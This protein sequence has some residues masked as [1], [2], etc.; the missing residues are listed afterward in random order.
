MKLSTI[1]FSIVL[2]TLILA[3]SL[4]VSLTYTYYKLDP[5]GF[6]ERL[7]VNIDKPELQC[8]GKCHLN[9]ISKSQNNE[10]K[11]PETLIDFK[12]ILLYASSYTRFEFLN[13]SIIKKE[14]LEHPQ[15]LYSFSSTYDYFHPPKA[16]FLHIN[17]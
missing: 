7:C 1:L 8:N 6:I 11:T 2:T 14:L 16:K 10:Q 17:I 15:N 5:L 12:D 9:K 3:N 4:R 13:Q